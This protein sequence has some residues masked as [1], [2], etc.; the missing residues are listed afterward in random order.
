M[1]NLADLCSGGAPTAITGEEYGVKRR[2]EVLQTV[3]S[4][5]N[6]AILD[7]GCG[8]GGY[9]TI[10]EKCGAKMVVAIDVNREYIRK[11]S[12]DNKLLAD[13]HALPFRD[14]CFDI[15]LMIEVL[16]HLSC[17]VKALGEVYRLLTD[18][19]LLLLS[20]PNKFYPF[21][22]H[23]LKA[24]SIEIPNVLSVGI[25]FLSWMP[26]FV[27]RRIERAKIYT[28][29]QMNKLLHKTGFKLL[30]VDYM[31][32]PLDKLNNLNFA[33]VLRKV[34]RNLEAPGLKH[35]GCHII[36]IAFKSVS[37]KPS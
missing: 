5:E 26:N 32:P 8:V 11:T 19:G 31:M 23:G 6:K 9:G 33:R 17:E 18:G 2:F 7:V 20:V 27:R 35:F 14:S 37:Q 12:S 24:G 3:A 10:A 4:F 36:I 22:T 25:P 30:K 1:E 13:A 29:K 34:L 21:E 16:E 15:I 28:V